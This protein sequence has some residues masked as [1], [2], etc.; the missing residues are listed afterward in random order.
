VPVCR[1]DDRLLDVR[2]AVHA[3][4][5]EQCVVVNEQRIVLGRLGRRALARTDDVPVEEAMSAGP[6]TVRP[7]ITVEQLVPRMRDRRLSSYLVTTA[8]GELVGL[9]LRED[10][11]AAD[12]AR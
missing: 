2:A 12:R 6:S 11:E 8:E 4:G 3:A 5:W 9:V 7:S 1:L 10:A